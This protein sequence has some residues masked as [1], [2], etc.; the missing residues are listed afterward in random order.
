[1]K[2][3]Q[4]HRCRWGQKREMWDGRW[5]KVV[6]FFSSLQA[7]Y[8]QQVTNVWLTEGN[9]QGTRSSSGFSNDEN[10]QWGS[11]DKKGGEEKKTIFGP[12]VLK[13]KIYPQPR[14]PTKGQDDGFNLQICRKTLFEIL[15]GL[16]RDRQVCTD[17]KD[18]FINRSTR[19]TVYSH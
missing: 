6:W 13:G 19:T 8:T 18:T 16:L 11:K 7:F 15:K 12:V 5:Q 14:T 9:E 10:Q 3:I 2:K 17:T 1:M 4:K